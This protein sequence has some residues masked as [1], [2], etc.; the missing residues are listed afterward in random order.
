LEA[1]AVDL[2][3]QPREKFSDNYLTIQ[4]FASGRSLPGLFSIGSTPSSC[5]NSLHGVV[6]VH[7]VE[8]AQVGELTPLDVLRFP[9]A[10]R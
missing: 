2:N 6:H 5:I 7:E 4:P 8:D 3:A 10:Q 1:C 9:Q